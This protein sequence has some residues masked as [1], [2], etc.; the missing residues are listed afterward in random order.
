MADFINFEADDSDDNENETLDETDF[1]DPMMIDDSDDLP[2]NEPSFYRFHKQTADPVEVM[3]RVWEEQKEAAHHLEPSNYLEGPEDLD[4][5]LDEESSTEINKRKFLDTLINPISD[6]TK[7]NSFFSALIYALNYYFHK[8][9]DEISDKELETKIG[10]KLFEKLKSLEETCILDL[11]R[12][13]FDN[14][15]FDL[16]EILLESCLFLRVYEKKDKFRY[17]F[18]Q[19]EEKNDT[20]KTLSSS[21][22][23]KFNGFNVAAPYLEN[24]QKRDL[25][26]IDVIYDPVRSPEQIIKC[27]ISTD[28]RFAYVGKIPQWDRGRNCTNSPYE[29][30]YCQKFF[31][32]KK[33]FDSHIK[34]S[35]GKPGVVYNFNVQNIVTFKDNLK[36]MDDLSFSVYADFE[37]TAPNCDFTCPE[38]NTMFAVSYPLVFAWHPKLNLPRQCVVRAFNHSVEDLTD[39][40]YLTEEQLSLRKQT[41]T[42]QL[43]DP[44][45]K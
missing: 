31:A 30:Y 16:N 12:I 11:D 44:A 21:L 45:T 33:T 20:V 19:T 18:H 32:R 38:N 2:N 3:N 23:I 22:H 36:Y 4:E 7:K 43:R 10:K 34:N 6:Q 39:A 9:T 17:L 15:C 14:M 5:E 27:Y 40:G 35:S 24:S 13:N 37:T 41:T 25:H 42:E 1:D 29:C 28:I 8:E 26:R